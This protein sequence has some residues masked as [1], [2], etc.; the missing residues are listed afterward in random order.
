LQTYKEE[1]D[2]MRTTAANAAVRVAAGGDDM[3]SKWQLL[4]E[5][6]KHRGE[7]GDG[8][9]GSLPG[10]MS[11]HKSSPKAGKGSREQQDIEKRGYFSM[12]G[13]GKLAILWL[14]HC[15]VSIFNGIA[16]QQL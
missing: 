15:S 13:P 4:A 10:T 7:G 1:D 8:S 2:K 9:S 5:K 11:S 16:K 6:N 12:H 14:L 3:L